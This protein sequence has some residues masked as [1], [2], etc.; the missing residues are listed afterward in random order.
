MWTSPANH[1]RASG[2]EGTTAAA[3]RA[4]S[5][6]GGASDAHAAT[7]TTTTTK[8]A[9]TRL[10][11]RERAGR[12]T[13]MLATMAVCGRRHRLANARGELAGSDDVTIG[14]VERGELFGNRDGVEALARELL[15]ELYEVA[16]HAANEA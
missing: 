4:S 14:R 13:L 12:W 16:L 11:I 10:Q 5:C 1:R 15:F 6:G 8:L 7:A 9:R 2:V 3:S